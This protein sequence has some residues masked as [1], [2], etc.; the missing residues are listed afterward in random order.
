MNLIPSNAVMQQI[1][2]SV[3]KLPMV[4]Q[5]LSITLEEGEA[6]R[7]AQSDMTAAFYLFGLE[8]AWM[9]FLCFNLAVMAVKGSEIEKVPDKTYYLSCKVLQMGWSSAVSVMQE[10]SQS[11]LYCFGLPKDAREHGGISILTTSL[12]GKMR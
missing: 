11:L 2:G 3:A 1:Q 6:L 7:M 4:T 10:I 9:R 5:Y 12:R 8:E